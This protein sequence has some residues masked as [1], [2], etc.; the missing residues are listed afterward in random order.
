MSPARSNHRI[1]AAVAFLSL[2]CISLAHAA[3]APL[4]LIMV[5]ETGCRFCQKWEAA[6][7]VAYPATRE[8]AFAPLVRVKRGAPELAAFAPVVYTPTFIVAEGGNEIGRITG[9]PGESFFWEEL[10]VLLEKVGFYPDPAG[11]LEP[12]SLEMKP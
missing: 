6:V 2:T 1:L 10:A 11:R 7:G 12:A 8:G 4:R 9:Y 3:I 5:E